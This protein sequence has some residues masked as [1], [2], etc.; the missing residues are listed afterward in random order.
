MAISELTLDYGM[1]PSHFGDME[2]PDGHACITGP[3][4]D[5]VDMYLRIR[6]GKIENVKFHT[7]GCIISIAACDAASRLAIGKSLQHCLDIDQRSIVD[8]LEG[9]PDDHAHCALLAAMTL[10]KAVSN[11]LADKTSP[12]RL[13][14]APNKPP[15][16]GDGHARPS[17]RKIKDEAYL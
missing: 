3:C 2:Q 4:G 8:H 1:N 12:V 17:R 16:A 7:D 14:H 10:H 9:L 11:H 13:Q 15:D 6:E 5:T